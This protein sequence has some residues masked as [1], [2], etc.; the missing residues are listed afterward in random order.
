[1]RGLI[2]WRRVR[3]LLG[4]IGACL[5]WRG[6]WYRAISLILFDFIVK[7][8]VTSLL[9]KTIYDNLSLCYIISFY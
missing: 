2:A 9:D 8:I 3:G 4:C 5:V 6:C 7:Y 1:M